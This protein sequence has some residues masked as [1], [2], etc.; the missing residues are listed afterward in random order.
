MLLSASMATA[1]PPRS[2]TETPMV[3]FLRR[4]NIDDRFVPTAD[5]AGVLLTG[6]HRSAHLS[7]DCKHLYVDD[8]D[9]GVGGGEFRRYDQ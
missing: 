4:P 8:Q 2:P 5:N 7:D 6:F 3:A 9:A 1:P